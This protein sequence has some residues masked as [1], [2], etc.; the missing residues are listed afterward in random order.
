LKEGGRFGALTPNVYFAG[1]AKEQKLLCRYKF[2]IYQP[3]MHILK[4]LKKK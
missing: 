4:R 2:F 1:E 3:K